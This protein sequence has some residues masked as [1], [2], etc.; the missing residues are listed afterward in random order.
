MDD[1]FELDLDLQRNKSEI[2]NYVKVI[3]TFYT[4]KLAKVRAN[5][6]KKLRKIKL[7]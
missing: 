1:L 6:E 4:D 5:Y 3:E 2:I 7:D